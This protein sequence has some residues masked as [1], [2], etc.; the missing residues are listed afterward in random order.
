CYPNPF[1]P[2]IQIS[3]NLPE[4]SEATLEIFNILGQRVRSFPLQ[5]TNHR[6][7][8]S[9]DAKDNWDREVGMGT[10]FVRLNVFGKDGK[11]Q[12]NEITKIL[13]LK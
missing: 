9:W 6:H 11:L 1:N 13:Y 4:F 2:I 7:V 3:V 10:Y 8:I 12:R 5:A